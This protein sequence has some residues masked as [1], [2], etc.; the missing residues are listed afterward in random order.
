VGL[1]AQVRAPA[2]QPAASHVRGQWPA[3]SSAQPPRA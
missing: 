1:T 2:A 3:A